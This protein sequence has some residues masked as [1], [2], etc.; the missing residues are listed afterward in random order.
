ML[1]DRPLLAFKGPV[2]GANRELAICSALFDILKAVVIDS[3]GWDLL[4][5]D[6]GVALQARGL[7]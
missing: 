6:L 2:E 1:A 7:G 4:A 3:K 5:S